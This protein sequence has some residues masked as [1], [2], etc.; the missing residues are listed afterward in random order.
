[1]PLNTDGEEEV[2]LPPVASSACPAGYTIGVLSGT[3]I[4]KV[5]PEV[6]YRL[7]AM[8]LQDELA[9]RALSERVYQLMVDEIHC[10][11]ERSQRYQGRL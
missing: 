4:D 2:L 3:Y 6:L 7:S 5:E 11:Q 9:I 10:R 8:V 1:M